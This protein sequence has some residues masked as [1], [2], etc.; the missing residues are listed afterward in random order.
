MIKLVSRQ[1]RCTQRCIVRKIL[2][3]RR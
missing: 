3:R 1:T 2:F